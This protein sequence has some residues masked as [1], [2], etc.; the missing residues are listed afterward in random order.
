MFCKV[1]FVLTGIQ[2]P[3]GATKE[4]V[5]KYCKTASE[6]EENN[7]LSRSMTRKMESNQFQLRN[8]LGVDTRKKIIHRNNKALENTACASYNFVFCFFFFLIV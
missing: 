5:F 3:K 4:P 6:K 7:P 8:Y 1:L 2:E